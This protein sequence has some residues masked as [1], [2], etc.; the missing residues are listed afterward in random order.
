MPGRLKTLWLV[1]AVLGVVY[2]LSFPLA[3]GV[4]EHPAVLFGGSAVVGILFL[5]ALGWTL[6]WLV[7]RS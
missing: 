4:S 2:G 6:M 7:R 5:V 3:P 1:V